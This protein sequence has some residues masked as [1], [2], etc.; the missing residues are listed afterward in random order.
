ML[1]YIKTLI[2]YIFAYVILFLCYWIAEYGRGG[3]EKCTILSVKFILY[4]PELE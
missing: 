2:I 1:Q 3:E 4:K